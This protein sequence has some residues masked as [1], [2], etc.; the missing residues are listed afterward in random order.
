MRLM[1]VYTKPPI[2]CETGNV[3]SDLPIK[4]I[5]TYLTYLLQVVE[6]LSLR[7]IWSC[8]SMLCYGDNIMSQH[9]SIWSQRTET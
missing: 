9:P 8:G 3:F 1:Y 2:T 5:S 7:L 4:F 6:V